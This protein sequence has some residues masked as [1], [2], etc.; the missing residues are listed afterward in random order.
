MELG[1]GVSVSCPP[2][3][4]ARTST[5]SA[6]PWC[7][8]QGCGGVGVVGRLLP[9][10]SATT[11]TRPDTPCSNQGG[12]PKM[13]LAVGVLDSSV[14]PRFAR[15]STSPAAS[16]SAPSVVAP[17]DLAELASGGVGVGYSLVSARSATSYVLA[18]TRFRANVHGRVCIE[19]A[20][21]AV[22]CGRRFGSVFGDRLCACVDTSAGEDRNVRRRVEELD[23]RCGGKGEDGD[24]ER[25]GWGRVGGGGK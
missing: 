14:L 13:T 17:P 12:A 20:V 6:A 10:R 18:G 8:E 5:L 11:S 24:R 15:T 23:D 9:S 22:H 2:A 7:V 1:V 16:S 25:Q 4:S 21:D 3:A 19:G